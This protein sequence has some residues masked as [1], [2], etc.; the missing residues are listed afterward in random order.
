MVWCLMRLRVNAVSKLAHLAEVK[1][2]HPGE[3]QARARGVFTWPKRGLACGG[4]VM[5]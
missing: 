4:W 2:A 3:E 1:L 5:R